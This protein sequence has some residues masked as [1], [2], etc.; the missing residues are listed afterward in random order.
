VRFL[1]QL[2]CFIQDGLD[3]FLKQGL[4]NVIDRYFSPLSDQYYA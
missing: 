2:I 3:V 4:F 1:Y